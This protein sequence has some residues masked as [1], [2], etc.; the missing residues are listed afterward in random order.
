[1][2]VHWIGF[3]ESFEL[4][5]CGGFLKPA[6]LF[7]AREFAGI[8]K[9]IFARSFVLSILTLGLC[10]LFGVFKLPRLNSVLFGSCSY[11]IPSR[12]EILWYLVGLNDKEKEREIPKGFT[13]CCYMNDKRE[14][15]D[16]YRQL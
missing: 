4:S 7:D 11:S 1:V 6:M 12:G 3:Y 2:A 8:W 15:H 13:T 5:K 9:R 16:I 10:C 14:S